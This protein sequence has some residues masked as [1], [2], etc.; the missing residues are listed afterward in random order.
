MVETEFIE[1]KSNEAEISIKRAM[2]IAG[3]KSTGIVFT[4]LEISMA[5]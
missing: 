4:V 1:I 2:S 5:R 3:S